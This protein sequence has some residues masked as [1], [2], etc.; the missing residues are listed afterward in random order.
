MAVNEI[1]NYGDLK[2]AVRTW[3]NRRDQTTIDKIPLFINFAEKQ[4]T[5]LIRLPYYETLIKLTTAKGYEYVDI[6][7]DFLSVKHLSVN[8][9]TAI[10]T[11]LETFSHLS[12][13]DTKNTAAGLR[14]FCRV[15]SMIRTYPEL[16]EGDQILFI[17]NRDI[18]EMKEDTDVP[19]S[20]II[21]PDVM[22]YLAL[23]HASIFLRDD[24]Q[25]QFW[26]Q[27]ALDAS[28]SVAAQLEEAEWSGSALVSIQYGGGA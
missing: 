12:T 14:Y 15:G 4:F 17:Y 1:S 26:A 28:Q 6:P 7:P 3:L 16:V 11:D 24:D 5:R 23:R 21:A 19:Y 20:L 2:E 27:K 18:P 25:E 9:T 22:L 10:R 13:M 8:G